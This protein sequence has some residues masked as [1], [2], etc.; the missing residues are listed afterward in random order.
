MGEQKNRGGRRNY[1]QALIDRLI[2]P[3]LLG[4]LFVICCFTLKVAAADG[5]NRIL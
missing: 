2:L 5:N 3:R 4:C 1:L